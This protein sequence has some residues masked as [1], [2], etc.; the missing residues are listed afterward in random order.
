MTDWKP[1]KAGG[2]DFEVSADG[3]VRTPARTSTHRRGGKDV[4]VSFGATELSPW[5][6]NNGYPTISVLRE[7]KRAKFTVHRLV[8]AGWVPGFADGLTVN[9]INGIKTDN[10]S[11]NL[12]WMSRAANTSEQWRIGLVDIAG[13]N[14][15]S[16][17]LDSRSVRI[18]RRLL[19]LGATANEI[20]TLSGVSP[21]TIYLI[22]DGKRWAAVA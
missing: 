5:I 11:E 18:I 15:P 21:S 6:G 1:V 16:R 17:K 12:E 20:A 7:G 22:R 8:A 10:R 2:I 14:H 9:H 19:S 3:R 13:D 4:I